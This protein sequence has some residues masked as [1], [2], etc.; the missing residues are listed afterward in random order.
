M[1]VNQDGERLVDAQVSCLR[2]RSGGFRRQGASVE[3]R[4]Q[5]KE[6]QENGLDFWRPALR[7]VTS[8]RKER[9]KRLDQIFGGGIRNIGDC[10]LSAV[11]LNTTGRK[12][13]GGKLHHIGTGPPPVVAV[14]VLELL[15]TTIVNRSAPNQGIICPPL[16]WLC[17]FCTL[18][19]LAAAGLGNEAD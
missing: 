7:L 19:I 13:G 16:A 12:Q 8:T 4:L 2:G 11:G 6:E 15:L 17:L 18:L 9:R 3:E 1:D 5:K 10:F 14:V